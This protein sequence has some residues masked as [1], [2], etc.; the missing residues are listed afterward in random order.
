MFKL[1]SRKFWFA[2]ALT[3]LFIVMKWFGKLDD[4]NFVQA[5]LTMF[6]IY[7]GANVVTKF[8]GSKP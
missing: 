1:K 4:D 6:G 2:I 8:T 7:S 5:V 3:V